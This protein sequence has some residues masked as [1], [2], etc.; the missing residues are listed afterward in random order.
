MTKLC[1]KGE[2]TVMGNTGYSEEKLV[3][4]GRINYERLLSCCRTLDEAGLW[5]QAGQVMKQPSTQVLDTYVQ[6]VL[7]NLA[8]HCG[9]LL[10][11]QKQF[12]LAV[13][14]TNPLEIPRHGDIR[15]ETV[16]YAI[17]VTGLP[18]VLLQ[19]CG[20]YD[21]AQHTQMS[22]GFVDALFNILLSMSYLSEG[23]AELVNQFMQEYFDKISSFL[24]NADRETGTR[25]LF[26]KM[27]EEAI[28]DRSA[29][30]ESGM[31]LRRAGAGGPQRKDAAA[32]PG[33]ETR[34]RE[35]SKS[36]T[37]FCTDPDREEQLAR[38]EFQKVKR[39]MQEKE[40]AEK[41]EQERR[42][43]A[44]LEE[45]N[46]LVGLDNVKEEIQSLIN[47]IKI[48]KLREA[49]G[50]PSMEM[51]YHMVFTGGPGT[52]KTTVARLVAK[53][54]KELGILSEGNLVETDRSGLVAGYVGQTAINVREV[55]EKAVGGVLFIDEAY[56][57]ANQEIGNDFGS[58]AVDTL[59]KLMEDH[60][61]NLVVIVAG[62]TEEMK[63]F[64]KSNTG[65][66]SRF[67]KYITFADY[68]R[69]ELLDILDVMAKKAGLEIAPDARKQAGIRLDRMTEQQRKDFGNARGVR[70]LFEKIV[71]NQANR[72]VL[73]DE[74]T[75]QQLMTIRKEDID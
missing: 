6:S 65:L 62:Y 43:S 73:Y 54:Y 71:V 10:D 3:Q 36:D 63:K 34:G 58:E 39:R 57:L 37:A 56:A 75:R 33:Q 15:E 1:V 68:S 45:L 13:T 70:N 64:L 44:L 18:P 16:S 26:C 21:K 19:L 29:L 5:E 12:I 9:R 67:N 60:R 8:I 17:R 4:L 69:E 40:K 22:A 46:G 24:E 49:M 32:A 52:G 61:D 28:E 23:K 38:E 72:L 53:I 47:L 7:L 74:P 20:V 35:E 42:L 2:K 14:D 48:R 59:V 66:I 30:L 25:Y 27:S 31:P 51:S 11:S 55:V 41:A 50:M